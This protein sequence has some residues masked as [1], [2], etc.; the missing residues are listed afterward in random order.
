MSVARMLYDSALGQRH[1]IICH[2]LFV[3]PCCSVEVLVLKRCQLYMQEDVLYARVRTMGIVETEF[4]YCHLQNAYF[5]VPHVD[6]PF[7][8]TIAS[9]CGAFF[10]FPVLAIA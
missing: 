10:C 5:H 7:L 6:C 9:M 1:Q 2:L 8:S 3:L 4:R